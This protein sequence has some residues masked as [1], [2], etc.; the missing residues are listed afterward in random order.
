MLRIWV[1]GRGWV[2]SLGDCE[3]KYVDSGLMGAAS[4]PLDVPEEE[5]EAAVVVSSPSRWICDSRPE[6]RD[7]GRGT[8]APWR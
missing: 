6:R 7:L 5:M 4:D 2:L 1:L 3:G 8:W